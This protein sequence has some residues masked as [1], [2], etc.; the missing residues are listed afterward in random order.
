MEDFVSLEEETQ[1]LTAVDWSSAKE[2]EDVT[3]NFTL[4][5]GFILTFFVETCSQ[6]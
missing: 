4:F 2:E 5:L 6:I 3:G 1:L